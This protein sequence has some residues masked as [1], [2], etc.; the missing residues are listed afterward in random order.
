MMPLQQIRSIKIVEH[1]LVLITTIKQIVMIVALQMN[2]VGW[3]IP[4]CIIIAYLIT[5]FRKEVVVV[6][7][8]NALI[9]LLLGVVTQDQMISVKAYQVELLDQQVMHSVNETISNIVQLVLNVV[10]VSA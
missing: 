4:A 6:K 3:V 5:H 2:N 8:F 1:M 9:I 7:I 10:A